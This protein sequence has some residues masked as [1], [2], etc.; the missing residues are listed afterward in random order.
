MTQIEY[1]WARLPRT[2]VLWRRRRRPVGTSSI[3]GA[4]YPVG[5]NRFGDVIA[6]TFGTFDRVSTTHLSSLCGSKTGAAHY[7]TTQVGYR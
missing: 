6:C 5:R 1:S 2:S 3:K 4:A 7:S